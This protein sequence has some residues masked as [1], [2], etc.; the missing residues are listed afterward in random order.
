VSTSRAVPEPSGRMQAESC[1]GHRSLATWA[2]LAV[3]GITLIGLGLRLYRLDWRS[4]WLDEILT[5]QPAHLGGPADVITWSQA[6]IN[7][8]PLFY[9]FTWF[10]GRWGD[11]SVILRMP[12]VV[13]GTLMIPAVYLLARDLFG[14][15]AGMVAGI[16][17]A[18]LPFAV[19]YSQEARNY[20]LLMLMTTL[21]M[22][23]AF[24]SVKRGR[25]FDWIGLAAF[26]TLN[27][28]THYVALAATVAVA[29]YVLVL[30]TAAAL[31]GAPTRAKVLV[32]GLL[33]LAVIAAGT[34]HWRPLLKGGYDF[35]LAH[36]HGHRSL[37]I[38]IAIVVLA[39]GVILCS[40]IWRRSPWLRSAVTAPQ[41]R[42]PL[43]AAA[44]GIVVALA[45][46][47][48]VHSLLVFL[49]RPDQSV[50][51]IHLEHPAGL[52]ELANTLAALSFS[53][54][55]LVALVL[56]LGVVTVWAFRGKAAESA[57]LLIWLAVPSAVFAL[58]AGRNALAVDPR[59][60]SFLV[61]AAI[62]VI[63]AAVEALIGGI[64]SL[65]ATA[66][67]SWLS[68]T[69]AGG[70]AGV[71][72]VGLLLTQAVPALASTYSQPKNDY[73][74]VA[75]RIA[76]VSPPGS[77]IISVGNY[78]DW[79][80]ICLQYYFRQLRAQVE[81]VDGL[82]V[83][84]YVADRIQESTGKVWGVVIFPSA[85]QVALLRSHGAETLDF[86][87]ATDSIYLVRPSDPVP[88]PTAQALALLRWELPLQPGL[89]P[90][91][92]A[93]ETAANT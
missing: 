65:A 12:A 40:A 10:L 78:A 33:G 7:Q 52:S 26:T 66:R 36:A 57:L 24:R 67:K 2:P 32:G 87:D 17:A 61:P 51:Q 91:I 16:L 72:A 18:V 77:M 39:G 9:M 93:L 88:S 47:P 90:S 76:A 86:V 79:T 1:H 84:T 4:L 13:A 3:A 42:Q 64:Q 70:I 71:M 81:V 6:A 69:R 27:L 80:V 29:L 56:G 45:Y 19:W 20:S 5:S 28:Y 74:A 49:G 22:Y 21:Q 46:L 83:D 89:E 35:A 43:L 53:G 63:A 73:R 92:A 50:G 11:S 14:T 58:T 25:I 62:I 85:Q 48:W 68:S 34:V 31:R 75:E 41:S 23:F 59:Y 30:V 55:L 37:V 15:R 82:Q 38:G 54:V 60:L 44:T 8:M